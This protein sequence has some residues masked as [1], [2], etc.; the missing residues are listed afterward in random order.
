MHI[1]VE[2]SILYFGTPVIL[3]STCN[4]DGT[5]NLAPMS[6]AWWLG[7]NCM[8]GLG[9]KGH[10]AQNL[11]REKEC[12]LNLPSASLVEHVNRLARL[13]GSDPIPPHKVAMGYRHEKNKFAVAGLTAVPGELVAPSR[14]V[15]CPVQ[16]EAVLE[17]VHPFGTRPDKPT[18]ALAFEVR[19]IR[20]HIDPSILMEGRENHVSPDKWRPLLMSF[21]QFYGLGERLTHSTLAEIP[22]DAYRPVAHMQREGA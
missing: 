5:A 13:T 8:L 18:T 20:A 11:L 21:C 17:A 3:L 4:E 19:I 9:A 16:L 1:S 2:P 6:S 10:T 15:E 7:W 12:V 22:E 14:V